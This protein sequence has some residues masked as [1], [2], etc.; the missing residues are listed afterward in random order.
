MRPNIRKDGFQS[1]LENIKLDLVTYKVLLNFQNRKVPLIIHFDKPSRRFYFALIALI[2]TE[3]KNLNK[4]EFIHIS[5]H[6]KTLKLLDKSL[7]GPYAS[8]TAKGMW[9][10]I[11]KAWRHR[12]PD[13]ETAAFFKILDRNLIPP[14]EKGGKYRFDCSDDECDI[15]ANLF[16]YDES[17]PWRFRF[18]IDSA[19]LSLNDISV[20]LGDLRDNSAWQEF[21]KNLSF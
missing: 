9:D 3:M 10:K 17:N 7:A 15:W 20:T 16:G 6:E 11:R 8:K 4:P 19:S 14:Y 5:K 12:L 2:V 18:A 1:K 13:L 21:V